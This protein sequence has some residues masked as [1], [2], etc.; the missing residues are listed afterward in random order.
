M[1]T[2]NTSR[3]QAFTRQVALMPVV[4]MLLLIS[5]SDNASTNEAE[6]TTKN[7]TEAINDHASLSK[8][9]EFPGGMEA[10][11]KEIGQNFKVPE[12]GKDL[13]T[14]AFVSFVIEKDG[15]MAMSRQ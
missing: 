4:A 1:M 9:P 6:I 12:I 10:F 8:P 14:K 5:C 7:S 2:K 11:Y 3:L 13:N 15:T